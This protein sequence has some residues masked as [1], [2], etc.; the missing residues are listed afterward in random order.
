MLTQLAC[1]ESGEILLG[2]L[3]C[4]FGDLLNSLLNSILAPLLW[5]LEGSY[6]APRGPLTV[7]IVREIA[8]RIPIWSLDMKVGPGGETFRWP[9][10]LECV[11]IVELSCSFE[12]RSNVGRMGKASGVR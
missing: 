9:R 2:E 12:R 11:C 6:W 1:L 7:V 8:R 3:V 10:G 5:I 4:L